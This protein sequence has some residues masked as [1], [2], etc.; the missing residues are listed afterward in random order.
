[1]SSAEPVAIK[2]LVAYQNGTIA[3]RT[4]INKNAG[5]VTVFAFD[6]GQEL[7]EHTSPYDALVIALDGK[8]DVILS[9][10]LFHILEGQILII[11]A[12]QPHALRA[13]TKFKMLLVMI[14][15]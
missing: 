3:S 13:S 5:S 1:V 11:P 12:N 14:R 15:K 6:E 8:A 4:L 7:S 2:K 9:G 10:D